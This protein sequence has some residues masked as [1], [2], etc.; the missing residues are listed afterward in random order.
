MKKIIQICIYSLVIMGVLLILTNCSKKTDDNNN[1]ASQI[2]SLTTD[3]VSNITETT[4]TSGGNVTSQG[5]STV[6]ARGVCWSTSQNPT[7]ADAH[8]TDG[9]GTGNFTSS[10]TGLTPNTPYY[11]RAYATNSSGTGYGNLVN[12]ATQQG[13]GGTV[14]DIDGN[15]YHTVTI[16]TQVWMVEN[17]KTTKYNDG[18]SL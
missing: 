11:V 16:G 7:T 4:A 8:T 13:T 6:T 10:L 3:V 17:L 5:S 12:F 1:T 18:T 15:V 2:P 9:S 14:T